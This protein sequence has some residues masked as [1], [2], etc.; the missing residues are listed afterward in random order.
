[1]ATSTLTQN[2]KNT[3]QTNTNTT[4]PPEQDIRNP[5]SSSTSPS[6]PS[7]SSEPS[8]TYSIDSSPTHGH[9]WV[10]KLDRQ[11]SWDQQ[12]MRHVMQE[13][14]LGTEK[15]DEVGFTEIDG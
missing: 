8:T 15:G 2:Y 1:M 3:N 13:R 10:P 7:H 11:Q 4:T 5:S 12:E 6:E 14:L 9:D